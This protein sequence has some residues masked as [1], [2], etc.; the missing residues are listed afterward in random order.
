MD[1]KNRIDRACD[2]LSTTT[3][4]HSSGLCARLFAFGVRAVSHWHS[5]APRRL[6]ILARMDSYAA[7]AGMN[8]S[9]PAWFNGSQGLGWG[10]RTGNDLSMSGRTHEADAIE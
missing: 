1:A 7:K 6:Q 3:T 9:R 4:Y 5:R 10:R 8:P 2:P